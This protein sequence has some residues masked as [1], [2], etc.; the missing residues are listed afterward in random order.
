MLLGARLRRLRE[1]KGISRQAAGYAIRASDAKIS[2]LE[3]GRVGYK[4]RDI[5]DLLT[6][7][8]VT[9]EEERETFFDL[10]RQASSPGWWH[11]YSD[12]LPSWFEMYIGLEQAANVI[13][14]YEAQ[15]V[16]SLFQTED[17]VRAM[18]KLGELGTPSREIDL[19][20]ELRMARQE[21]LAREHPP[22]LWVVI[23]EA[24]LQRP[25]GGPKV[26]RGQLER[27]IE[28]SEAPGVT[29]QALTLEASGQ[30]AVASSFRIL[31]FSDQDINDIAYVEQLTSALY[32]DKRVDVDSYLLALD[33]LSTESASPSQTRDLLARKIKEL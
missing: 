21:I 11:K 15:F 5:A 7:Y 4:Q 19:R 12:M 10:A 25:I 8:G 17:Y 14:G 26:M 28:V 20:V 32:L 27:L 2:R 24:A 9:D 3:L 16:Y 31:R 33:R 29:L 6:L 1:T 30:A 18:A 23:D 22:K 13:R